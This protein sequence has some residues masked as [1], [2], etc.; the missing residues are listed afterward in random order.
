MYFNRG[1]GRPFEH[2]TE[3]V[4]GSIPDLARVIKARDLDGDGL[5][6]IFVGTTYQ[7]QSRLFLGTGRGA[8]DEHTG[9]HLPQEPL[10]LGDAE[11]G[12]VDG[13][14]DLDL[15]LADWGPGNNM[16]NAGG[17][18]RFLWSWV[19]TDRNVGIK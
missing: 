5:T 19:V 7:T 17:A 18:A 2:R 1:A 6:D 16:R 11:P 10:S 4:F 9:T 14:G 3:D 13:D 15:V 8:F 12:D